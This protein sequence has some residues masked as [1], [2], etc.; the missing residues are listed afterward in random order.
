M[1]LELT[2]MRDKTNFEQVP[3]D[4]VKKAV[5]ERTVAEEKELDRGLKRKKSQPLEEPRLPGSTPNRNGRKA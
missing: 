1:R 4:I 5:E 2:A 3:L